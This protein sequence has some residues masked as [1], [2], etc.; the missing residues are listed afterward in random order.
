MMQPPNIDYGTF[1][2]PSCGAAQPGSIPAGTPFPCWQCKHQLVAPAGSGPTAAQAAEYMNWALQHGN[3][4]AAQAAAQAP[5]QDP[6]RANFSNTSEQV[7]IRTAQGRYLIMGSHVDASGQWCIRAQDAAS[8]AIAWETP[9]EYYFQSCPGLNQLGERGGVLFLAQSGT[10]TAWDAETG[11]MYWK[12]QLGQEVETRSDIEHGDYL[13]LMLLSG[14]TVVLRTTQEEAMGVSLQNGQVLWRRPCDSRLQTTGSLAVLRSE[15]G[16][17]LIDAQGQVAARFER[18]SGARGA[19]VAGGY[20][21]VNV[22]SYNGVDGDEG[23]LILNG[24]NGQVL[25]Y[26]STPKLNPDI[27]GDHTALV[28]GQLAYLAST[29]FGVSMLYLF[30]PRS[31]A[32]STEPGFFAKFFGGQ[33]KCWAREFTGPK[34]NLN[35]MKATQDTLVVSGNDP[36]GGPWQLIAYEPSGLSIRHQSGPLP[37]DESDAYEAV[38]QQYFAYRVAANS[39]LNRYE[40]RVVHSASGQ[41]W[42]KEIEYWRAHYFVQAANGAEHLVVY[43]DTS[44]SVFNAQDGSLVG[45]YPKA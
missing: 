38:G 23:L 40:L 25:N 41:Q 21:A 35:H 27:W 12:S 45:G 30:D 19:V 32:P 43:H 8:G 29:N 42:T 3:T 39:E 28:A 15:D 34:L 33:R 4:A 6:A 31:Q 2:C 22:D 1:P 9:R 24:E 10:L 36:N 11:R 5:A 13:D 14:G 16:V 44:I 7:L 18:S 20:V 26:F 37:F 17:E